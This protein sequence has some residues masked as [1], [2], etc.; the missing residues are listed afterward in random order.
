LKGKTIMEP[1]IE[2]VSTGDEVL[3]G[4]ITDTNT[5]WLS[6]LLLEQGWQVRRRFTVGDR[7]ADLVELFEQRS[8]QADIIIVNGGLGPTSDDVCAEAMANAAGVPLEL[9]QHWL[10]IMQQKYASRNRTMPT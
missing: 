9:N 8:H 5:G 7:K 4:L 2:L 1:V 6:Q 3:T 10:D